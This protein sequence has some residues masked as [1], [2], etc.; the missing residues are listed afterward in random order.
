MNVKRFLVEDMSEAVSR[1]KYELGPDA[2]IVN[3]R[4]IRKKGI[5]G[6]FKPPMIEVIAA[7]ESK[8]PSPAY[9]GNKDAEYSKLLESKINSLTEQFESILKANADTPESTE[10]LPTPEVKEEKKEVKFTLAKKEE[11][12]VVNE[13]V[14]EV[15]EKYT[16]NDYVKRLM[17]EEISEEI[18]VKVVKE[19][20]EIV[21]KREDAQMEDVI[22]HL[23]QSNLGV[24]K[25]VKVAKY[26]RKIIFL[27]GPTGVGKTTTI[28]KLASIFTLEKK[29][30][31]CLVACDT[32]RIAAVEQLKTYADILHI[33]LEVVKTEEDFKRM[34]QNHEQEDII[35]VDTAGRS[36]SDPVK[37]EEVMPLFNCCDSYEVYLVLS[38]TTSYKGSMHILENYDFIDDYKLIFTKVDEAPT[39]GNLV[40]VAYTAKKN[41][42]YIT[43]GQNVPDDIIELNEENLNYITDKII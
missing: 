17:D 37:Q 30:K 28:A 40:N 34:L 36:P 23:L 15:I 5:T 32:Y 33:P 31:V 35:L 6:L 41:I 7:S 26:R 16:Q 4:N 42:G 9:S 39:Y 27:L 8:K 1:I 21:S 22:R 24:P 20:E 2:V 14:N 11:N 43:T 10:T 3:T 18:A 12:E 19:A 29:A 38:A 25:P 13:V